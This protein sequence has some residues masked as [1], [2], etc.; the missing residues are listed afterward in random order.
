VKYVY[1]IGRNIQS[2]LE[3]AFLFLEL[4]IGGLI[5]G[6]SWSIWEIWEDWFYDY[7]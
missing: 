7:D 5:L 6:L 3:G 1:R 2:V 4:S